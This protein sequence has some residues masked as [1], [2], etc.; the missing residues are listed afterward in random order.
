M[1]SVVQLWCYEAMWILC[2]HKENK[3]NDFILH[4]HLLRHLW[5]HIHEIHAC[6]TATRLCRGTLVNMR[7]QVMQKRWK[8]G[9][10]CFFC[11]KKIKNSLSFITI[12]LVLFW[13]WMWSYHND[14]FS[15]SLGLESASCQGCIWRDR[16]R[17]DL[18]FVQK[19]NKGLTSVEWHGSATDDRI[20]VFRD[21]IL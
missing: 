15:T 18:I 1:T 4:F 8:Y 16:K 19:M 10:F 9:I 12:I 6:G 14:V 21:L 7:P 13:P 5:M 2:L 17:S 11:K 3:N 20:E